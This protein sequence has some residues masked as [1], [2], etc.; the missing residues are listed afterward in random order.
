M[1]QHDQHDLR[2]LQNNTY[3][4]FRNELRT[5]R[6]EK[7][8]YIPFYRVQLRDELKLKFEGSM[9]KMYLK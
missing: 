1:S 2:H 7:V 3:T 8:F 9:H 5:F 4:A 6:N